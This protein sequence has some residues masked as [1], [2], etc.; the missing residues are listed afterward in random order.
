MKYLIIT[1]FVVVLMML[2]GLSVYTAKETLMVFLPLFI[3]S[4]VFDLD[5]CVDKINPK[6]EAVIRMKTIILILALVSVVL[7]SGCNTVE[8]NDNRDYF[9]R[10]VSDGSMYWDSDKQE[11][12]QKKDIFKEDGRQGMGV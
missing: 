9:D 5:G 11:C 8:R 4:F 1:T 3:I 12:R 6:M 10:C 2:L 7:V